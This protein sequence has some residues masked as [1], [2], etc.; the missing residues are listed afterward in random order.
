MPLSFD[1]N[2]NLPGARNLRLALFD[3]QILGGM[4]DDGFHIGT[5]TRRELEAG[6]LQNAQR[7]CL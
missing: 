4:N 2:L 3:P 5:L 1:G 7:D 6:C